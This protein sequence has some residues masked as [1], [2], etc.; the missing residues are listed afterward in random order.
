MSLARVDAKD[1][2]RVEERNEPLEVAVAR[3]GDEV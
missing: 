2:V 1:D 3:S